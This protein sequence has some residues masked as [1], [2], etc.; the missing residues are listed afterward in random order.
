LSQCFRGHNRHN[1][2]IF[3]V[4]VSTREVYI[5]VIIHAEAS[6][7]LSQRGEPDLAGPG[8]WGLVPAPHAGTL[9]RAVQVDTIKTRV[10]SACS[11]FRA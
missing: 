10:E 1:I 7:S 4:Y 8:A 2:H 5:S 9:G 6:L 11:G 3:R